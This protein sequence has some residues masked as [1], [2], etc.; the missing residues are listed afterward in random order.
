MALFVLFCFGLARCKSNCSMS[1]PRPSVISSTIPFHSVIFLPL[2]LIDSLHHHDR[3]YRNRTYAQGLPGGPMP[4]TPSWSMGR[5]TSSTSF[6]P[7]YST[8]RQRAS[9][10]IASSYTCPPSSTSQCIVKFAG[11]NFGRVFAG[12]SRSYTS[13]RDHYHHRDHPLM[14]P[15]VDSCHAVPPSTQRRYEPGNTQHPPEAPPPPFPE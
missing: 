5:S 15:I 8:R 3:T 2:L 6:R 10:G 4:D 7:A 13:E 9:S 14:S 11:A 12:L 1:I